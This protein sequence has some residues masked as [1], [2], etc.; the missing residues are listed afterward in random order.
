M[1]AKQKVTDGE[2]D[3]VR[4][5]IQDGVISIKFMEDKKQNRSLGDYFVV[6]EGT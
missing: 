5:Q 2:Q 3:E 4:D 1:I 6:N